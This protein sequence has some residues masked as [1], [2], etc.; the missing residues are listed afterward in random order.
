VR[1]IR[2]VG[3]GRAIDEPELSSLHV[4]PVRG[5]DRLATVVLKLQVAATHQ[6][7]ISDPRPGRSPA[8]P[9][10]F[11]VSNLPTPDTDRLPAGRVPPAHGGYQ[12]WL[13]Q[14]RRHQRRLQP[15]HYTAAALIGTAVISLA[16]ILTAAF[17]PSTRSDN[18][19]LPDSPLPTIPTIAPTLASPT[20][21]D[22]PE[23]PQ[24]T[25]VPGQPPLPTDSPTPPNRPTM[26][27]RQPPPPP[28]IPT[29]SFE[30]ESAA[31]TLSGRT[32]IHTVV[33]ASGGHTI[34]FIGE[35]SAN[36]LRFNGLSLPVNG[37]YTLAVF[38]ISG[39]GDRSATIRIDG[40]LVGMVSFPGT[41]DW[42]TVGSLAMR[43]NLKAGNNSIEFGNPEDPAPDIDRITLGA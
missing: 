11:T 2:T 27:V 8:L 40:T 19:V 22:A 33:E 9:E 10:P 12:R 29:A 24:P 42:H 5:G 21:P 38:Y 14:G 32:R 3:V 23:S 36:T 26:P 28:N 6:C 25:S 13:Y 18:G 7:V 35:G 17:W 16:L 1:R 20:N 4:R 37:T 30:A 41:G 31:N 15:Q 34:G 39:D 43:I